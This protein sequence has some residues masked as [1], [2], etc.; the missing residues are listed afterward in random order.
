MKAQMAKEEREWQAE[1][2]IRTLCEAAEI[3]KDK[4]RLKRARDMAKKKLAEIQ[5]VAE[6]K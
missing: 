6:E 3:R 1:Q 4:A 2:D 5:A